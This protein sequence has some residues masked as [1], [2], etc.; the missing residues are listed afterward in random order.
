MGY[1][2]YFLSAKAL[3]ICTGAHDRVIPFPGGTLPGVMTAGGGQ[4]FAKLAGRAPGS[5][6]VVAGTGVFL[7]AA[8]A[9]VIKAGGQVV[10]LVEAQRN[11]AGMLGLLARFP[12]RWAEAAKLMAPVLRAGTTVCRCEEVTWRE[13]LAALDDGADSVYGAKLWTRAGMGR[14]Q[15]RMCADAIARLAGQVLGSDMSE[16]GVQPP[17][18][19]IASGALEPGRRNILGCNVSRA[20]FSTN[21]TAPQRRRSGGLPRPRG[22]Q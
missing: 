5:R 7:W 11:R 4:R 8:A 9:S 15:G 16:L 18:T 6:V 20:P 21:V 19:P 2:S 22:R 12:E 14:C 17:P 3:V 1:F 10:T 13:I